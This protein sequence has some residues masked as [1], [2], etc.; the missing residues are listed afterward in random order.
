VPLI[1]ALL[2]CAPAVDP[3]PS[4][5][6]VVV[7]VRPLLPGVTVIDEDVAV[8]FL[9]AE[10]VPE[11]ALRDLA[12]VG[13]LV[14]QETVFPGDVLRK[15]RFLDMNR[16]VGIEAVVPVGLVAV[17]VPLP[18]PTDLFA[19]SAS[20][21]VD[22]LAVGPGSACTLL[23]A[24]RVVGWERRGE[25]VPV[26]GE[27][28]ALHL[29][30]ESGQRDR[31]QQALSGGTL[32]AVGLRG[33]TDFAAVPVTC[34]DAPDAAAAVG[35]TRVELSVQ[36][37]PGS[38]HC[39]FEADGQLRGGH[40]SGDDPPFVHQQDGQLT[41]EARAAIWKAAEEALRAGI[42][43]TSVAGDSVSVRI[44]ASDGSSVTWAWAFGSEP[45][46]PRVAELSRLLHQ[47]H[48]GGW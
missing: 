1:L 23:S 25:A 39:T 35:V 34:P 28:D 42:P 30:V 32:L 18:E 21:Y 13:G 16:G 3:A 17:R 36:R 6:P 46:D 29:A 5:V 9:P 41:E 40:L 10:R 4:G 14:P 22:V 7:A 47:H 33:T 37:P 2:A 45:A 48:V 24:A 38:A 19:V 20:A 8:R 31:V 44:E 11:M 12:D 27:A 26:P 15:E 43:A